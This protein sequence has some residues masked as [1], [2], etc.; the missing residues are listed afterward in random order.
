MGLTVHWKL[1]FKGSEDEAK[2]KLETIKDICEDLPVEEVNG[3][4]ELDY[5]KCFNDDKENIRC[6][7][8][9]SEC[10]RWAKIQYEAREIK[11]ERLFKGFV[12]NII[13]GE[14]CEPM[15]IGLISEDGL[16][17]RGGAFTKTQYAVS[18][19][20]CHLL[21]ISILDICKKIGILK[22]V[23]DEGDYWETRNLD[24]LAEN[25]N[26]ST[27]FIESI[28]KALKKNNINVISAIDESKNYMKIKEER[29]DEN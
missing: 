3:I 4:W 18:F 11:D 7:G 28:N 26:S 15:N 24:C 1:D 29:G 6:A 14:G 13:I 16:N 21:V 23:S 5:S 27:N 9:Y 25:I 2:K 10:Y 22:S 17:W 19:V 8:K 12:V 20:K